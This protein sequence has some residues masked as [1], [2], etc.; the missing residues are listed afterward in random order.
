MS[1]ISRKRFEERLVRLILSGGTPGLPRR[2]EDRRVLLTAICLE[3]DRLRTFTQRELDEHFTLWPHRVGGRY[4]LDPATIRRAMVDDG[5]L[6]RDR[7][8]H[9]YRVSSNILQ[10][11]CEPDVLDIDPIECLLVERERRMVAK[12]QAQDRQSGGETTR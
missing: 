1:K 10:G 2:L 7:A 12:L 8:G 3:L 11:E 9:E 5:L 6:L 4:G